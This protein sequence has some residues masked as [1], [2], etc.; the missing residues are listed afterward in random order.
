MT[1]ENIKSIILALLVSSSV[2]L[3]W[4]IWTYQPNYEMMEKSNTVEKVAI[5]SKK[6][7]DQIIKPDRIIFHYD[8]DKH[9]GTIKPTEIDRMLSEIR[10]WNFSDFENISSEIKNYPSFI[11]K[12]G[13]AVI[14]FPDS[15]PMDLY[16]SVIDVKDSKLPNFYFDQI[17]VDVENVQR[18]DGFV[19]FVSMGNYEVYRSRVPASFVH[20]FRNGIFKSAE[21]N[22]SFTAY[23]PFKVNN[24]LTLFLEKEESKMQ[25]HQYIANPLDSEKFKNAL[26]KDPSVVQKSKKSTGEEYTNGSSLMRVYY[27]KNTLSYINPAKMNEMNFISKNLLKRSIDFVNEHGG[28]TNSFRFADI[29][30]TNHSVIFRLYDDKGYPVFS[31]RSGISEIKETWGQSEIKEYLRSNFSLGLRM[32]STETILS[33]GEK[34]MDY[35]KRMEYIDVS[36]LQNVRIGYSM[37]KDAQTR[38]V[39]L[40]PTW[41]YQYN[42]QWNQISN[43]D[44]RGG[45]GNGLEQN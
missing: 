20:N 33:S 37:T 24:E 4:S 45:I 41:Y 12:E 18:E 22:I 44:I 23:I 5:S 16:K 26:F 35:L 15:I 17:V 11:H 38:I 43:E 40:E 27:D 30:E 6:E 13:H 28:W 31:E 7:I 34:V 14:Q 3:T 9:V 10:K 21:Y 2:L 1:Y 42:Q 39:Y 19:Y 8:N 32:E 25:R 29:D 36:K